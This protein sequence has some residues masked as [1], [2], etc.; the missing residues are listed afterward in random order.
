MEGLSKCQVIVCI[1][2]VMLE[3]SN[4]VKEY[5]EKSNKNPVLMKTFWLK[6]LT[7]ILT[8]QRGVFI[9]H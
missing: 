3:K 6:T 5:K 8:L 1:R 9:L 7:D 2:P 4:G